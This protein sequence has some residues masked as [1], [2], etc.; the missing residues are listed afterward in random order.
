MRERQASYNGAMVGNWLRRLFF[1]RLYRQKDIRKPAWD[2][3]V[4]PPELERFVDSRAPGRAVDLGCGTGTNAVFLAENG[5]EVTGVDFIPEAIESARRKAADGNV[6][7][8]FLLKNVLD[9]KTQNLD[10]ILDIG[11]LSGLTPAARRIMFQRIPEM[12]ASGGSFLGYGFEQPYGPFKSGVSQRDFTLLD[13]NLE[14]LWRVDGVDSSNGR[15]SF[16]V[17]YRRR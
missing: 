5:W 4:V 1:R 14:K 8:T 7:V 15:R 17:E 10:L 11:C 6:N 9:V 12:L 3:G 16:W 13:K 2:T